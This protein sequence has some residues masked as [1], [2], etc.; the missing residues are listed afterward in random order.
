MTILNAQLVIDLLS[1]LANSPQLDDEKIDEAIDAL[2]C[3][4]STINSEDD[5]AIDKIDE[6]QDYLQYLLTGEES[7]LEEV[8]EQLLGMINDL[9]RLLKS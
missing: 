7:S 5:E 1:Q 9:Q 4:K 2:E 3:M 8:Q 6:M